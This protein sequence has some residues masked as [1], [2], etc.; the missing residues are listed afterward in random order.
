MRAGA[1]RLDALQASQLASAGGLWGDSS[2]HASAAGKM[3]EVTI[4]ELEV[5]AM[6]RRWRGLLGREN[7]T[8]N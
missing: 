4:W 5:E 1:H 8:C 3:R 6:M 7:K 2:G